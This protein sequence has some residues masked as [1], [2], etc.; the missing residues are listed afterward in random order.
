[1]HELVSKCADVLRNKP[2]AHCL[3]DS[4]DILKFGIS[5]FGKNFLYPFSGHP[6]FFS[7]GGDAFDTTDDAQRCE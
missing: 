7:N 4:S 5:L 1:M 3:Q 6:C 2:I